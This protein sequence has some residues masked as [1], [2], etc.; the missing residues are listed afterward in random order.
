V[1]VKEIEGTVSTVASRITEIFL[2]SVLSGVNGTAN[3]N[4][5]FPVQFRGALKKFCLYCKFH[6]VLLFLFD[7]CSKVT[8]SSETLGPVI[9]LG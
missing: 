3:L 8:V 5:N 7:C 4:D 2:D 6:S 1:I 9:L